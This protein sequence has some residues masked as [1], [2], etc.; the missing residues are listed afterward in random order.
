MTESSSS[1]DTTQ[2]STDSLEGTD[3]SEEDQAVEI[4]ALKA[5]IK[6]LKKKCKPSISH[7]RAWLK[8]VHRLS[9]NKRFR[10]NKSVSKQ[11]RKKDKP[12]LTLDD[13][14]FDSLD[15]DLDA[16]HGMDYMDTKEIVNKGRLNEET[17]ELKLT[18]DTK[19]IA[20]DKGSGEKGG[21]TKE[22]VSTVRPDVG[23]ADPIAPPLT[24]TSIFDDEDITMAQTLIKMKKEKA[25]EKGVSIKDIEDSLRPARSILTLKP[26]P[27]IDLKDKG[28]DAEVARLVYEEELAE[29]E[30]EKEKIQREEEASKAAITEM[31]DEVQAGIEADALFAAKLQQEEREEYIIEERVKFLAKTIAAW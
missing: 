22:L 21:S 20:Q 23:H 18:T 31:Y 11:V 24:T 10:K 6:K 30:R 19:E 25:K 1:H 17:K 27:T 12:E 13:N 16:D 15:A 4:I 5:R 8:S 9:I 3:R 29:L 26:L 14:T 28:K 2:D 7:H